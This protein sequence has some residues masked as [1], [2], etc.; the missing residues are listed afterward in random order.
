MSR[1]HVSVARSFSVKRRHRQG[2]PLFVCGMWL[3]KNAPNEKH[4]QNNGIIVWYGV[5]LGYQVYDSG[6]SDIRDS[7]SV[8][9]SRETT[10]GRP[11]Q[12]FR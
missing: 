4:A 2:L 11:L 9:F 10:V 8:A 7:E 3:L 12:M 5:S 6:K 1:C